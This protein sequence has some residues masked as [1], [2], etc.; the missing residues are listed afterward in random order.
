MGLR[1]HHELP[2]WRD[3][4][5]AGDSEGDSTRLE[6]GWAARPVCL[7]PA[8]SYHTLDANG[9]LYFG[10]TDGKL[11]RMKDLDGDGK[12]DGESEL[13]TFDTGGGPLSGG[14]SIAPGMLAYSSCDSLYVFGDEGG[15]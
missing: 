3:Y 2:P 12:F 14:P 15:F 1:W 8:S 10:H 9:A 6:H 11:Y 5:A 4:A 7:P 13:C